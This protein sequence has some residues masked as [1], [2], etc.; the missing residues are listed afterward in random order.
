MLRMKDD[1]FSPGEYLKLKKYPEA[2]MAFKAM[3]LNEYQVT[4]IAYEL[5]NK[6]PFDADA[7]KAVLEVAKEQ[8]P[9]S[10]IVYSRWGDYYIKLLDKENAVVNYKQALVLDPSN[11]QT[12]DNLKQ[13][14]K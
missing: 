7:V 14:M 3:K 12:K 10:S 5:L 1:E 4:Y 9:N 8:H 2:K 6:K 11:E 13:L